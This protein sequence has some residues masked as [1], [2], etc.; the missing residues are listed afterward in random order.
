MS[1]PDVEHG[2]PAGVPA[3]HGQGAGI[4]VDDPEVTTACARWDDGCALTVTA[5]DE[6]RRDIDGLEVAGASRRHLDLGDVL[7]SSFTT[8]M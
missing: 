8:V 7:K 6:G 2:L 5:P 4:A 1:R 3:G